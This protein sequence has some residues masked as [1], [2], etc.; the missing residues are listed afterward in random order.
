MRALRR[1]RIM[2]AFQRAAVEE[3]P[4]GAGA[5]PPQDKPM[6]E[7]MSEGSYLEDETQE[8]SASAA[9]VGSRPPRRAGVDRV[10]GRLRGLFTRD[11]PPL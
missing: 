1:R 4:E 11:A 3:E 10:L 8:F 5:A 9:T 2:P 6:D 7:P